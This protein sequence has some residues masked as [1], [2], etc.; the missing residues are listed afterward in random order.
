MQIV[1]TRHRLQ[2]VMYNLYRVTEGHPVAGQRQTGL[3]WASTHRLALSP[4]SATS[5]RARSPPSLTHTCTLSPPPQ[6]LP[7]LFVVLRLEVPALGHL[8]F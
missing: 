5:K 8:R 6:G 1:L 7:G 2:P 4:A 3:G